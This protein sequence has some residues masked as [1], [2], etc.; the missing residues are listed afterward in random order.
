MSTDKSAA[1]ITLRLLG[2]CEVCCALKPIHLE[3]TKTTALLVYLALMPGPHDR[4]KL[5]DLLWGNL[6]DAKAQRALRHALWNLRRFV[7]DP[8]PVATLPITTHT[9]AWNPQA[10]YWLDAQV[11]RQLIDAC[12]LDAAVALYQGDLLDSFYVSNAPA[13]EEWLLSEREHLRSALLSA[14]Q[15][16]VQQKMTQHDYAAGITYARRILELDEWR[17]EAHR[18]LMRLLVLS[19]QR[20]AALVQYEKCCRILAK[21]LGVQPSAETQQLYEEIAL[22]DAA[23]R[24]IS[25][26]TRPSSSLSLAGP[27]CR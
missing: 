14:L 7:C 9:V 20:S 15:Q 3:T 27:T 18:E 19:G 11:F 5:A 4:H 8:A 6:P 22:D 2:E 16:L 12:A 13:F 23:T 26:T 24:S 1:W 25:A 10:D 21:E 17:E